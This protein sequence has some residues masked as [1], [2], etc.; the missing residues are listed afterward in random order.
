[1]IA[2]RATVNIKIGMMKPP[3]RV[4]FKDKPSWP[5]SRPPTPLA[6]QL[7]GINGKH[8]VDQVAETGVKSFILTIG[9][10]S[11]FSA[12]RIWRKSQG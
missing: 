9:R 8:T 11:P 10:L 6:S 12:S 1:M 3:K 5:F 2:S 4:L 7:V